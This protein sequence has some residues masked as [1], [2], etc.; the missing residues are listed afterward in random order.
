MIGES[1][2]GVLII[3]ISPLLRTN[4][5]QPEPKRPVAAFLNSS[6][7]ASKLPN[8]AS[9]FSATSPFGFP[10]PFGESTCQKKLWFECPPPL[11]RTAVRTFSGSAS[12]SLIT[13]LKICFLDR[14]YLQLQHLNL[15]HTC[16][17]VSYDEYSWFLYQSLALV[18]RMHKV[19]QVIQTLT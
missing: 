3:S 10:P 19:I 11:L 8:L 14:H 17:D 5:A 13:L 9:I 12:I 7:N 15:L 4:Q 16:Y 1:W 18:H 2:F 6:L